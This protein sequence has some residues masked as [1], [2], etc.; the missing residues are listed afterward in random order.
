MSALDRGLSTSHPT[1]YHLRPSCQ[2]SQVHIPCSGI[3]SPSLQKNP[4]QWLKSR[5]EVGGSEDIIRLCDQGCWGRP[6]LV[7]VPGTGVTAGMVS[8]VTSSQPRTPSTGW[9]QT[10]EQSHLSPSSISSPPLWKNKTILHIGSSC[11]PPLGHTDTVTLRMSW[12]SAYT[13]SIK[14]NKA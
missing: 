4:L 13:N 5:G 14:I 3:P 11:R 9:E 8:M 1:K 7:L 12:Q 2:C 10:Q 6:Q